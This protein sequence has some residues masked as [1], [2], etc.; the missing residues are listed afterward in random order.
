MRPSI[1]KLRARGMAG[2]ALPFLPGISV[3]SPEVLARE[4]VG[5]SKMA[6]D[7]QDQD[8]DLFP[9]ADPKGCSALAE[10]SVVVHQDQV[11]R[12]SKQW[13]V[14]A[15]GGG[16]KTLGGESAKRQRRITRSFRRCSASASSLG[17]PG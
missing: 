15:P 2:C 1:G 5:A 13:G 12:R 9:V 11:R 8:A 4:L 7:D 10:R 6:A 17:R 16:C 14:R 3:Q